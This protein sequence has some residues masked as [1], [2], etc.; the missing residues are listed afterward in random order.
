MIG[1]LISRLVEVGVEITAVPDCVRTLLT[2]MAAN[3]WM[4]PE[5]VNREM[6]FLGWTDVTFGPDIFRLISAIF[7]EEMESPDTERPA[8]TCGC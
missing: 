4:R 3:P 5:E 8:Q 1:S 2:V 6:H 7:G